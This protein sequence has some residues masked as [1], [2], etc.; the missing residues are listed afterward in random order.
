MT[1]IKINIGGTG[2]QLGKFSALPSLG[3]NLYAGYLFGSAFHA[4]EAFGGAQTLDLSGNGRN[5]T[6]T[7]GTVDTNFMACS[8]ANYMQT[9]FTDATI[10]GSKGC[11]LIA[12]SAAAS[13]VASTDVGTFAFPADGTRGISLA[14]PSDVSKPCSSYNFSGGPQ[15]DVT[16]SLVRSPSVFEFRAATFSSA[17][18]LV[19]RK[20]SDLAIAQTATTGATHT[21]IGS[22]SVRIGQPNVGSANFGGAVKIA[23]VMVATKTLTAA[24]LDAAYTETKALLSDFGIDI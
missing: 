10:F 16:G 18:G 4:I 17:G 2:G 3:G 23:A 15:V 11:T 22:Q 8:P 6:A 5:L 7:G 20:R 21:V 19:Y 14:T 1:I 12:V 24:E 9:P 13:G